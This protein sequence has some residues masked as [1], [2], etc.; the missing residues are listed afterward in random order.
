MNPQNNQ[1]YKLNMLALGIEKP[2]PGISKSRKDSYKR[3]NGKVVTDEK[4]Q[5][6]KKHQT[7]RLIHNI[8]SILERGVIKNKLIYQELEDNFLMPLIAGEPPSDE[9]LRIYVRRAKQLIAEERNGFPSQTIDNGSNYRYGLRMTEEQRSK[10][11]DDFKLTI[12]KHGNLSNLELIKLLDKSKKIPILGGFKVSIR[13][14]ADYISLARVELRLPSKSP[15]CANGRSKK[16][17][18]DTVKKVSDMYSVKKMSIVEI[19]NE[20]AWSWSLTREVLISYG[21]KM[22][23]RS[24]AITIAGHRISQGKHTTVGAK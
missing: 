20:M 7:D 1:F 21:T 5:N 16:Y 23:S 9:A 18:A 11:I 3:M 22:R 14:L 10:L 8:K 12:I 6:L 2:T 17:S 19:A 24:K 15:R 4:Q 13:V